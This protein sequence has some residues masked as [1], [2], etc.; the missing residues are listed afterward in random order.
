MNASTKIVLGLLLLAGCVGLIAW[1]A[2]KGRKTRV[3]ARID[4]LSGRGGSVPE[5]KALEPSHTIAS[6]GRNAHRARRRGGT[7]AATRPGWCRPGF[8]LSPRCRYF[9]VS[10]FS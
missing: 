3:D 4:E 6:Q 10:R 7:V 2:L 9:W 1:I 8:T 5:R